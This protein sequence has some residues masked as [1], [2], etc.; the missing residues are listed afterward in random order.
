MVGS[1][2]NA[3]LSYCV[4]LFESLATDYLPAPFTATTGLLAINSRT[5]STYPFTEP[6][7]LP[8]VKTA[9]YNMMDLAKTYERQ[10][11]RALSHYPVALQLERQ[12]GINKVH[13]VALSILS[14]ILG[15]LYRFFTTTFVALTLFVYPA[16]STIHAIDKHDKSLDVHWLTYWLSTMMLLTFESLLGHQMLPAKIPFYGLIKIA[17]AVWMFL[18]RTRGSLLIFERVIRPVYVQTSK[19]IKTHLQSSPAANAAAASAKISMA[20]AAGAAKAAAEELKSAGNNGGNAAAA[21]QRVKKASDDFVGDA[22]KA[23][24]SASSGSINKEKSF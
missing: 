15:L 21:Q 7:N 14:I 3:A 16:V 17:L 2:R 22:S 6:L 20:K 24:L 8:I 10:L 4:R 9:P 23:S 12:T 18:P 1:H 13:L 19:A 11:D 5:A